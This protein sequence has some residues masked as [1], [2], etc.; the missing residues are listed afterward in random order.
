MKKKEL[1]SL[2]LEETRNFMKAIG[3]KAY[4]GEQLFSYFNRN[5]ELEI[6]GIDLLPKKTRDVLLEKGNVNRIQILEKYESKTDDTRKY[7]FLLA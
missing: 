6:E 1:N 3:E 4:R 2:T 7:L 5:K